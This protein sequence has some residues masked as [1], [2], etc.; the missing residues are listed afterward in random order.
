MAYRILPRVMG[1]LTTAPDHPHAIPAA[2]NGP[3]GRSLI[4][5]G[6]S[7]VQVL[8]RYRIFHLTSLHAAGLHL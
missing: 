8:L 2:S 5:M 1:R 4:P 6:R 7:I 3:H